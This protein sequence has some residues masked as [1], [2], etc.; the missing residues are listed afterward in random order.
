MLY[1]PVLDQTGLLSASL[2]RQEKRDG[3]RSSGPGNR[4]ASN[5]YQNWKA[6]SH[7][8]LVLPVQSM[9]R[10]AGSRCS[11]PNARLRTTT[12]ESCRL[13]R[14]SPNSNVEKNFD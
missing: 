7:G 13:E 11:T 12:P 10:H 4:S 8:I 14:K 6:P 2:Q 3:A 9:F 1:F 5:F